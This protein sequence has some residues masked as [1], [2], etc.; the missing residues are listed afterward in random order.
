[1][2]NLSQ[3]KREVLDD[4]LDRLMTRIGDS[5]EDRILLAEV[6]KE[7]DSK[8]Y[9][10]IWEEHSERVDEQLETNVPVFHE[11]TTRKITTDKNA[12]YNFLLEGD[13]LHSLYLL[14]KTHQGKIDVIYID[15]PYNTGNKDFR[16]D[17]SIVD[18]DDNFFHSKWLSFMERRLSLAKELLSDNGVIYLS[19]DDMEVAQLKL[20]CD[21]IFGEHNLISILPRITK[22]SGKTTDTVA[23]NH[24][25]VLAYSKGST[26]FFKAP[27]HIDAAYKYE[28]EFVETR[29]K[30]KLNQTLDYDSLSYSASLDY[31]I[32]IDGEDFY[33]GSD[34]EAFFKRQKGEHKRADWAWRWSEQ[35]FNFGLKNGFVVVK[36][37]RNGKA[38]IYTKTYLNATIEKKESGEYFISSKPKVKAPSSLTYIENAFSNDNA[39]KD[40]KALGMDKSFDYSKPVSLIKELVS[41]HKNKD[42]S[43]L[44]FFAGSG[45][46]AQAVMQLNHEDGGKR[47]YILCTNN[48]NKICEE[49]T[50]RRLTNIQSELPHNLKYFK[51]DYISKEDSDLYA[52]LQDNVTCMIELENACDAESDQIEIIFTDDQLVSFMKSEKKRSCRLL[53]VSS[54]VFIAEDI[55]RD[56][57]VASTRIIEIPERYFGTELYEQGM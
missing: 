30:Y 33:P 9:G 51:T 12:P 18:K 28:D 53:Y 19:I 23:K 38:R 2:S 36:R 29:G 7:I 4:F 39:K 57:E 14:K 54:M 17:D 56:I 5:E 43:I 42:A 48:E 31:K 15:P 52:L 46:T 8:R 24:D 3:L 41:Y 20:L 1:M 44:D 16:Y 25:Y 13:N 50:Y 6:K 40:L 35:K 47:K 10:L 34:I 22:K 55:R 26:E 32:T 37:N 27:E 21:R 45:T 11:V 49:V